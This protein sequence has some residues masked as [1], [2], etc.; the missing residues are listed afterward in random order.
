MCGTEHTTAVR[1]GGD[2][3]Q[4]ILLRAGGGDSGEP[5]LD[6]AAGRVAPGTSGVWEPSFDGGV[7]TGRLGGQ[8]Q[9]SGATAP[10]DGGGGGVSEAIA[11]PAGGGASDLSLPRSEERRVGKECR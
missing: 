1:P 6:A 4:R 3:A 11:E 5:G 7:A 2:L 8:S 9:A 10:V